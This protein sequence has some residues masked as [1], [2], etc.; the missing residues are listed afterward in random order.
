MDAMENLIDTHDG[1][2]NAQAIMPRLDVG[3]I[4]KVLIGKTIEEPCYLCGEPSDVVVNFQ[5]PQGLN[6]L[7]QKLI[8]Y[9]LCYGCKIEPS[10]KVI[11]EGKLI[12]ALQA[13]NKAAL[14][15]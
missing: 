12:L 13:E 10:A 14:N 5:V 4:G 6:M 11:A 15:S 8:L 2:N 7:G 1:R 3:Q 9:G